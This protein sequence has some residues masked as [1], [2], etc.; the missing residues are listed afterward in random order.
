MS[1]KFWFSIFFVSIFIF[2]LLL[3]FNST[4]VVKG[5][6][7]DY[8][9]TLDGKSSIYFNGKNGI[10]R[11]SINGIEIKNPIK[12]FFQEKN[13]EG[14]FHLLLNSRPIILKS[15]SQ[16]LYGPYSLRI[17]GYENGGLSVYLN[18]DPSVK[19]TIELSVYGED[20]Y[21]RSDSIYRYLPCQFSDGIQTYNI[22]NIN[23]KE[24][25]PLP[26]CSKTYQYGNSPLTISIS[27]SYD[28][29]R[30][31]NDG[32]EIDLLVPSSVM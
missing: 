10:S 18:E 3:F 11:I 29:L 31:H 7:K 1:I 8:S 15:S 21:D 26:F 28:K 2:I 20:I 14:D 27:S 4:S 22:D 32:K 17:T 19:K 5:S 30:L 12:V 9:I 6:Y 25:H 23:F 24:I 13:K 16:Y